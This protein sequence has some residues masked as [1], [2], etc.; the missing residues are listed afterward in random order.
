MSQKVFIPPQKTLE[1]PPC[2]T[3]SLGLDAHGVAEEEVL[4]GEEEQQGGSEAESVIRAPSVT[5]LNLSEKS[6]N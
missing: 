1:Y 5:S 2:S 4:D 3:G 6:G